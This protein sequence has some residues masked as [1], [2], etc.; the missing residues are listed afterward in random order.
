MPKRKQD[1]I[2]PGGGKRIKPEGEGLIL[3]SK[4]IRQGC[5]KTISSILP[6]KD[7][8]L[9]NQVRIRGKTLL[10]IAAEAGR[11]DIVELLM[12]KGAQVNQTNCYSSLPIHAA[13]RCGHLETVRLLIASDSE[14]NLARVLGRAA[15][16]HLAAEYGHTA[17]VR[18]LLDNGANINLV[19]QWKQSPV[20]LAAERG[21]QEV[22][23][24]LLE[25]GANLS[26]KEG[27][28]PLYHA[29]NGG[30]EEA[31][32]LFHERSA[33]SDQASN[34]LLRNR[35]E[36]LYKGAV[37]GNIGAVKLLLMNNAE[38]NYSICTDDANQR[39]ERLFHVAARYDHVELLHFLFA[40]G[41]WLNLRDS[42][43]QTPLDKAIQAGSLAAVCFFIDSGECAV[44][45]DDYFGNTPLHHAA[46]RGRLD[47][48]E[49]LLLH[50]AD[51]ASINNLGQTPLHNA[52]Q[53]LSGEECAVVLGKLLYHGA[54]VNDVDHDEM[55]PL[56]HAVS[57]LNFSGADLL[58]KKGAD[59]NREDRW[60]R[61]PLFLAASSRCSRSVR[62]LL[63]HG[64]YVDKR[65]ND[66]NTPLFIVCK[67]AGDN[68]FRES[69][70]LLDVIKL[71]LHRGATVND[72]DQNG[73]SLLLHHLAHRYDSLDA[74]KL[75]LQ[76]GAP[77]PEDLSNFRDGE[78]S[79]LNKRRGW[80]P[81]L[82]AIEE[83]EF[84][85]CLSALKQCV[86]VAIPTK[87]RRKADQNA[88]SVIY[89]DIVREKLTS[90]YGGG[91]YKKSVIGLISSRTDDRIKT[92]LTQS[93]ALGRGMRLKNKDELST[94]ILKDINHKEV[95]R[96][97]HHREMFL[98]GRGT[99]IL[100]RDV[101]THI[102]SFTTPQ[103][104]MDL[105]GLLAYLIE[106]K[107]HE[108]IPN[109]Q[110]AKDEQEEVGALSATHAFDLLQQELSKKR[111]REHELLEL[112]SRMEL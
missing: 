26:K 85:A 51:A 27:W 29:A 86:K 88:T 43:G 95:L 65:N 72:V 31:L 47:V 19:N 92:M 97:I 64:A 109:A 103:L 44:N 2:F 96:H 105:L 79:Y 22:V 82:F 110:E 3:L 61:T 67:W 98:G 81:L 57:N 38:V 6:N 10:Y 15:P 100:N 84:P 112:S 24:L 12:K 32:R 70:E 33:S 4:A 42:S 23:G 30:D 41:G 18:L 9:I 25:R 106:A 37:R 7:P 71:L 76:Y 16:L 48:L 69:K 13:A 111:P 55:T 34:D 80:T 99:N 40:I 62:L 73:E 102:F 59:I 101:W 83:N 91:D 66:G 74:V 60:G 107:K 90:E 49:L 8:E 93:T 28:I 50:G 45:A 78:R 56:H 14:V 68:A 94:L 46:K 63:A 77:I 11:K 21:H 39:E 52:A 36:A 1:D 20:C 5:S 54:A 58:V 53:S 17:V 35:K 75:L 108:W 87:D 89:K 104:P